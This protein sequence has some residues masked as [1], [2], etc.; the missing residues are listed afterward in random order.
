MTEKEKM[1]AGELYDSSDPELKDLRDRAR[2]LCEEYCR[3]PGDDRARQTHLLDALLGGHG[4]HVHVEPTVW[5][6][7]GFNTKVGENFYCNH[8]CVFLDCNEIIF[9]DNVLIGPQCGFYAATHPIDPA[10]RR[11]GLEYARP[12]KVGSNVWFGGGVKVL[13]GVTIGDNCVIGAGAVVTHDIPAGS[14]AVGNPA[15][16]IKKV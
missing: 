10:V 8:D 5:F 15:E 3:T 1:L 7:Y 11:S 16:V 4:T 12:I 14:V 9:G 2:K 13:P 6:D